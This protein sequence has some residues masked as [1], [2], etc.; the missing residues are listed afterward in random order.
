MKISRSLTIPALAAAALCSSC[1]WTQNRPDE[2]FMAQ[3]SGTGAYQGTS[4]LR[5]AAQ[6]CTA[7]GIAKA[8]G[9]M[10]ILSPEDTAAMRSVLQNAKARS[11]KADSVTDFFG[12]SWNRLLLLG[13]KGEVLDSVGIWL[14]P[15]DAPNRY[16]LNC[17]VSFFGKE[18]RSRFLELVKPYLGSKGA[19]VQPEE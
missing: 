14:T 9:G 3:D 6:N 16:E 7:I 10:H 15:L 19:H 11:R 18:A 8:G 12:E 1:Q 17:T 2:A 13:S 5:Q 4:A